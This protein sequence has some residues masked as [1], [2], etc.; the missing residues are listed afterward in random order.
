MP[1]AMPPSSE[2][3]VQPYFLAIS[4]MRVLVNLALNTALTSVA[5]L[6]ISVTACALP[7]VR[8]SPV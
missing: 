2:K 7:W 8:E 3:E 6:G 5:R 1:D 4:H